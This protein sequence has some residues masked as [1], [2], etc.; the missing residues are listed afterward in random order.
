MDK[1]L[2]DKVAKDLLERLSDTENY[3]QE[4]L[5]PYEEFRVGGKIY[6]FTPGGFLYRK[7]PGAQEVGGF[8]VAI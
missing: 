7:D 1:S 3:P 4:A 8:S 2:E 5:S 6:Y